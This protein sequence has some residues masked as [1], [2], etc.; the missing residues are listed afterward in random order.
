M[1]NPRAAL[2]AR[3]EIVGAGAGHACHHP[4]WC[5]A[6]VGPVTGSTSVEET[7]RG[8]ESSTSGQL[9]SLR[10]GAYL[11]IA[12]RFEPPALGGRRG[13]AERRPH[14][15]SGETS[16]ATLGAWRFGVAATMLDIAGDIVI[17]AV[18]LGVLSLG[19]QLLLPNRD[20]GSFVGRGVRFAGFL[21]VLA[22]AAFMFWLV[23]VRS[24]YV[25]LFSDH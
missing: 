7:R 20:R 21:L 23:L 16:V 5:R 11:S 18:A 24:G 2:P 22:S 6:D 8:A 12:G 9:D 19:I 3:D 1:K 10:A 17:A 15:P 13:Q 14:V 4:Y 25:Q